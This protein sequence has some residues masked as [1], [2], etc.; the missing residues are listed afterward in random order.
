[1]CRYNTREDAVEDL[2]AD[3]ITTY[4]DTGGWGY[5][6]CI[7][8]SEATQNEIIVYDDLYKDLDQQFRMKRLTAQI[9][10]P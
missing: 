5:F 2:Q 1:M 3:E 8:R 4:V 10:L 6:K 7:S 9:D